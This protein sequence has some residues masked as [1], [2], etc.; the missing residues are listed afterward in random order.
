[1]TGKSVL[2]SGAGIA[3]PALALWLHRHGFDVTVVERAPAIREGGQAVDFRGAAHLAILERTGILDDVKALQTGG[4][5]LRVVDAE[6]RAR[7]TLP[8]SFTGGAV[9]IE[10]G[11]LADLLYRRTRDR[12]EY[13]FGDSIAE[14]TETADGVDVRF[15]GGTRRRFDLVVGADGLHSNVRRLAFGPETD[16]VKPSGYHIALYEVPAHLA[17]QGA[18]ELYNQPGRGISIGGG[19]GR[20]HAMFV[21]HGAE[22]PADHR[23]TEAQKRLVRETFTGLPWKTAAALSALDEGRGFY[24][25]SISMVKMDRYSKGRVVLIGDAGYGATCGGM[26][27]GMGLVAAYVLA[28]ELAA[29]GGD[30][31]VAF[32]AYEAQIRGYAVE[33][34]KVAGNAGLFLAPRTARGIKLRDR[35][36][37]ILTRPFFIRF[38]D[39]MSRK[40][41]ESI[42]LKDYGV[43]V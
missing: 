42:D 40:A 7:L 3:G 25:D 27:A 38:L 8:E 24:F 30:H 18:S 39:K 15:E 22:G 11:K 4:S 9:E 43:G 21:F 5:E 10:R 2:I 32:P 16:F 41:A 20:A 26:G 14:L 29:A 1:M 37:K 19:D 34:Q 12:V 35:L 36:H 28:G 31:T 6:G 33:C 23:D 17:V 13:L